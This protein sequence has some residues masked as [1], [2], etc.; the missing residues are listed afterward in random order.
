LAAIWIVIAAFELVTPRAVPANGG[1]VAN[2]HVASIPEQRRE[3]A[4]LLDAASGKPDRSPAD[5]PRS[6]RNV[7]QVFV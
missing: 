1:E 6:A 5:R 2:S 4:K 7:P 3:L